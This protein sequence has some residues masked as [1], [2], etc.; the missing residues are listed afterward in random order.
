MIPS[1]NVFILV[2]CVASATLADDFKTVQ[3]KEYKNVTVSRVEPD[4]IVLKSKSGISKV[5][6]VELPPDV[7]ERFQ[8]DPANAAHA[9]E[10]AAN[11]AAY[12]TH[13]QQIR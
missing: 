11:Q 7:Q 13:G 1:S 12:Q 5:Y 2:V 9:S 4:G 8:H 10:Q 6:F 3:G